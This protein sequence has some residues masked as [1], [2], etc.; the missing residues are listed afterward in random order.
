MILASVCDGQTKIDVLYSRGRTPYSL[1]NED[2]NSV[3]PSC[4]V[5]NPSVLI[6]L[7]LLFDAFVGYRTTIVNSSQNHTP[8]YHREAKFVQ[9]V[10]RCNHRSARI[11]LASHWFVLLVG[12]GCIKLE[13][14]RAMSEPSTT[15]IDRTPGIVYS[16]SRI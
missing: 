1:G 5:I 3:L 12:D 8:C 11:V 4:S 15:D 6:S 7:L 2:A 14:P 9:D 13:S 10:P 16:N